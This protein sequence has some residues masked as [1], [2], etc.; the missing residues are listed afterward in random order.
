MSNIKP[1]RIRLCATALATGLLL[2]ACG[3]QAKTSWRNVTPRDDGG[4]VCIEVQG[5]SFD[6]YRLS[7]DRPVVLRVRGPRRLKI[8]TRYLFSPDDPTTQNYNMRILVDG[9]EVLSRAV[10]GRVLDGPRLCE[11]EGAV[12]ALR[13]STLSIPTGLHDIQIFGTAPGS[14]QIVARFF[15]ESKKEAAKDVSYA[16]ESYDAVYH[17]QFASGKQSTYYHFSADAPLVFTVKGPTSLKVYTRL[18]FDHT[19]NGSQNYSLELLRDGEPVNVFHYHSS[20]LSSAA[21]I[22]RPDILPGDRK[23]LRISVPRGE[24]RYELRCVRP[25]ACGISTMIRIP[26]ADINPR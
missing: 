2:L 20:K 25:D 26:E 16:P 5:E 22:E 18:D 11:G 10:T 9:A 13:K 21:Y 24:H 6:Y 1:S 3:A 19:M 17:L 23:L 14:G 8:V 4:K 7:E 15:R 12:A